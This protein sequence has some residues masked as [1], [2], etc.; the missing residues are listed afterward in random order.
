VKYALRASEVFAASVKSDVA[1][2]GRSEK[3][4]S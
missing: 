2:Y 4:R 3:M 1:P